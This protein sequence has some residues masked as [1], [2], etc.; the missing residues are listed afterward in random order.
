MPSTISSQTPLVPVAV[1]VCRTL[2]L[3]TACCALQ[4]EGGVMQGA[5]LKLMHQLI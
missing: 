5:Q 1:Y 4:Y 2:L 3:V